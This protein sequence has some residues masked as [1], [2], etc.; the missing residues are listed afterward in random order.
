MTPADNSLG[1][2]LA[3][4][5]GDEARKPGDDHAPLK[6]AVLKQFVTFFGPQ[7]AS[8]TATVTAVVTTC[9]GSC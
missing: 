8:P 4:V 2:L 9:A 6:A 3:F 1:G 7:A 5:G